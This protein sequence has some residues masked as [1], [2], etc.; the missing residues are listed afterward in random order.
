M[1]PLYANSQLRRLLNCLQSSQVYA[2]PSSREE[3]N[4]QAQQL[5]E[6]EIEGDGENEDDENM[7]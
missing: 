4:N 7:E 2:F 1:S 3:E 5:Y 6:E